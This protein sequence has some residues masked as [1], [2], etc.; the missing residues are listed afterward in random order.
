VLHPDHEWELIGQEF[1]D[2]PIP[3]L[4]AVDEDS[5]SDDDDTDTDDDDSSSDESSA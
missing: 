1:E 4:K 5:E 3:E 2:D